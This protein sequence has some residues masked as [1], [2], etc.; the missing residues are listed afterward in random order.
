MKNQKGFGVVEVLI[1]VIIVGGL[2]F[3][4][5]PIST[6]LGMGVKPNKTIQSKETIL[7]KDDK[8][9]PYAYQTTITDKDIQQKVTVWEQLKS[10]P[11]LW[12]IL[13]FAGVFFAP[14]SIFMGWING[15]LK[16]GFKQIVSGIE[17]AKKVLPKDSVDLLET[18]LSKKM[19]TP[20]KA[21][22][23]KIKVTL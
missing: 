5:N 23:K 21:E 16:A 18:N 13:M 2:L 12:L 19:D 8:G 20:A 1:G 9:V 3:I 11:V 17:E 10:L 7:I 14:I 6:T 15:R 22:V 4:Q